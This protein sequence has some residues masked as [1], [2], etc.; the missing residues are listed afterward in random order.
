M[1][2]STNFTARYAASNGN[3]R[4]TTL[5]SIVGANYADDAPTRWILILLLILLQVVPTRTIP[6]GGTW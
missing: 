6:I 5:G 2:S 4:T 1:T 3:C